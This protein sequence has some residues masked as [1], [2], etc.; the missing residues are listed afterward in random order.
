MCLYIYV[1]G[2]ASIAMQSIEKL[3]VLVSVKLPKEWEWFHLIIMILTIQMKILD[4]T[5][6]SITYRII[7]RTNLIL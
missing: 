5:I 1:Y 3:G 7:N 2:V 6:I 4:F